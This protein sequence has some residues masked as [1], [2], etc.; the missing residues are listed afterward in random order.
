MTE[1]ASR[2]FMDNLVS[3]I[4]AYGGPPTNDQVRS[5]V[6]DLIQNWA[7]AAEGRYNLAY[8]TETYRSLQRDG[9]R[10]P[11]KIDVASSMFDSKAVGLPPHLRVSILTKS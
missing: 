8:I 2:E 5:R 7:S 11:P 9:F 6:L 10:F 3:I 4:K 1:I